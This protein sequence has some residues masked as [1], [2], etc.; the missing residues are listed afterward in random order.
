MS[1]FL[2]FLSTPASAKRLKLSEISASSSYPPEDGVTYD[3]RLVG[4]GKFA[5]SWVEGDQGS[6]LGSWLEVNFGEEKTIQQAK[7]WAGLWFSQ[8]YWHRANR[9][10]EVE[11]LFSDGTMQKFSLTDKKEVQDLTLQPAVST[12]TV[13]VKVRSIYG[14]STWSDTAISEVQFFDA[15]AGDDI[16][17]RDYASSTK[18]SPDADGNYEPSNISD[19]ILDSMWCEGSK[20]GTGQGE[21]LEVTFTGTQSVSKLNMINGIGGSI[22]YWMKGNRAAAATLQFSD[23]SKEQIAIKNTMLPQT[24]TFPSHKTSSVRVTF[25]E[26]LQGKEFNDLCIS[27][28]NFRE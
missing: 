5:S 17:V 14:G 27:E 4:D 21:W 15:E 18:L 19:G 9:P 3:A 23:G 8:D 10:K 24:I 25:D 20:D 12:S 7:I 6:G 13:R 2:A 11:L 16:A 22:K 1:F 28:A 26:V